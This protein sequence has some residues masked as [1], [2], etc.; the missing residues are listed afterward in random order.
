MTRDLEIPRGD[1]LEMRLR[2]VTLD[3]RYCQE[4][5]VLPGAAGDQRFD[6]GQCSG[7]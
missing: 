6:H 4:F 1:S 5:E 2:Q 3:A 7:R